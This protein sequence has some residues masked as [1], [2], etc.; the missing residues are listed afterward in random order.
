MSEAARSILAPNGILRAG[1]NMSNGLLVTGKTA[2]GDPVG[3]SPDMAAEVA[4]RLGVQLKL[5]PFPSPGELG[6]KANDD[7]W[8]IGNIGAEPSRAKTIDFT[9]AYAEIE[10]TYMVPA[11]SPLKKIEDV[12]KKGV[13]IAISERSAYD[14][15][16]SRTLKNAELVRVRGG[17][18]AFELFLNDKLDALA[19]LRPGLLDDL[20]KAQGATIMDGQFTAVQQA[21]G[22]RKG[23]DAAFHFL[24]DFVEECKSNGTVARLIEKH[25]VKGKLGVAPKA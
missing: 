25:G 23:Q 10:A 2:S 22:V 17:K 8:D 5:V 9:A 14:L 20:S 1:I 13:R 24:K 11:G 16:L 12:D 15:Y 7:V 18:A 19:G 3:V 6:D 4:K 21:I